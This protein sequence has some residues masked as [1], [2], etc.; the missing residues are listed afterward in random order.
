MV[1]GVAGR[2]GSKPEIRYWIQDHGLK[3]HAEPGL[4]AEKDQVHAFQKWALAM[5]TIAL[6]LAILA[7]SLW[8]VIDLPY[9][10]SRLWPTIEAFFERWL[11]T[12][13]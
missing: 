13:M 5:A 4:R 6:G 12:E 7:T 1:T 8:S 10:Y 2:R 3:R 9:Y 11:Q